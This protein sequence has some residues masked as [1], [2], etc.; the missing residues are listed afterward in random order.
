MLR[1]KPWRV[2]VVVRNH[3]ETHRQASWLELFFDL[4]FVVAVAQAATQLEHAFADGHPPS[5]ILSYAVVFAAVWWAWV[6]FTWFANVFDTDDV[7]YRV[8][9]FVMIGGSLGLAAGVPQMTQLDFRVGVLSYVIMRLAYVAQWWRVRRSGE[10]HWRSV[11]KKM[12][13]FTT[14][15][16]LGWVGFL[17]I[18]AEWKLPAFAFL[19]ALEL[20]I[21][22]A[23]GWDARKG[24]HRGHIV[25]RYGLFTII[26]L[27]EVIAASAVA[28]SKA[29]GTEVG[30][31]P[32]LTLALGGM[33]TVCALWWIYFDFGTGIA[34][35]RGRVSHYLWAYLHYFVFATLAAVGAGISL[36]VVWL[37]DPAHVHLT[38]VGVAMLVSG[39][40][41]AFL[42][43]LAL[44][45]LV[46]GE[47]EHRAHLWT[48]A[49]GAAAVLGAAMAT[50]LVGVHGSVFLTGA[51]VASLA[52]YGVFIQHRMHRQHV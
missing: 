20:V 38:S 2:P 10:F 27:G 11:A 35:E 4:A 25:E 13:A 47:P 51:L 30:T 9:M 34:L 26:V 14:I 5:G 44:I 3:S 31:I 24:G 12:I 22:A 1:A 46:A 52:A 6:A 50:P 29:I 41:A 18:P 36:S 49:L 39:S 32:L 21:P 19:F 45:E 23:A 17:W 7:P 28:I 16:Q 40:V 48:K 43:A 37:T 8:L 42:V 33:T 15:I